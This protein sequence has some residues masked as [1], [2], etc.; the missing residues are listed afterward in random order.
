MRIET[1]EM[2]RMQSTWENRVASDMS[3]SGVR[4]VT[5]RELVE[6]GFDLDGFLDVPLGY[7]QTNGTPELRA[8]LA[9]LYPGADPEG[10]EVTSGTSEANFI[11]ALT[12]IEP[13]DEVAVELPN[14][15]QVGGLPK[16]AGAKLTSFNLRQE[17]GWEPDWAEFEAAVN[18]RTRLVYLTNPNNPTGSVLSDASMQRIVA[19][20]DE[21]GAWLMADEVYLGAE[22]SRPRTPSFWGMNERV[23]VTSGLSK[24]YG[25][26]GLR[27]GWIIANRD[28]A[29]R[30]WAQHDYITISPNKLSD[31]LATIATQPEARERLY[32][33]TRELLRHNLPVVREWVESFDG[34][35]SW[36]EPE[37]GAICLV[38]YDH[39]IPSLELATRIRERQDAL[40]VPGI[41]FGV[42]GYLRIWLGGRDEY[43]RDGLR[44]IGNELQALRAGQ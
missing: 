36:R 24:A 43:L 42:E 6:L 44:R 12:L 21:V 10:I 2:E 23:I 22:I 19:R 28:I 14:Y 30:T 7:S 15:M 18:K 41:H 33:R 34:F 16:A 8:N 3:E 5:L 9:R 39:P 1:F 13:G 32:A 35:L 20:C 31:K 29:A 25:I 11:L 40:V 38:R 27:I 4:P 26:P 37:A 17:A